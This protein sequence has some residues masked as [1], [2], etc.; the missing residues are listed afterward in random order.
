MQLP[1]QA[2]DLF[3]VGSVEIAGRLVGEQQPWF[4]GQS[5]SDRDPLLLTPGK[6]VGK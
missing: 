2:E 1:H 4:H 5:P 3:G 6:L